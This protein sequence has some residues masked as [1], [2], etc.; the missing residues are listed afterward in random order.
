MHRTTKLAWA[1]L[2]VGLTALT[3]SGCSEDRRRPPAAST[4]A[5]AS[6]SPA[7]T[8]SGST[9]APTTA[10]V[11]SAPLPRPPAGVTQGPIV[12]IHG[13]GGQQILL[14]AEY[15]YGVATRLRGL[16]FQ[17]LET[18]SKAG[19]ADD[20]ARDIKQQ[21][22]SAYP[23]PRVKVNLI[24]HSMGGLD[25][26]RMVSRHGMGDRVYSLTTI[27]TPH[28]GS[29]VADFVHQNL[30]STARQW[31]DPIMTIFA[32]S[33]TQ[34]E[35][36]TTWYTQGTFNP[37]TPDDPR[38]YY[39]SYAG[40]ADP[41]GVTGTKLQLPLWAPWAIV[42]VAEGD[43]DGLVSVPSARWGVFRGRIPADHMSQIGHIA[44]KIPFDHLQFYEDVVKELA[45]LGY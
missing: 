45:L 41:G 39:Q 12:L 43:N 28:H 27:S 7:L 10:S 4:A 21:I 33:W 31:V 19:T 25:A 8:S 9:T 3:V 14:G 44:G 5:T 6:A 17:V 1:V 2:A 23:D 35:H 11:T 42:D 30:P 40:V 18:L 36:L 29:P 20:H 24:A 34:L 26:R 22:L 15:F 38:V 13:A 37:A 32:Y 16:G